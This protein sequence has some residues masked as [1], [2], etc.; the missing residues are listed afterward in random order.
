MA[1]WFPMRPPAYFNCLAMD[2]DGNIMNATEEVRE[3]A[4][5]QAAV[6]SVFANPKR[7]LGFISVGRGFTAPTA[8]SEPDMRGYPHPAPRMIGCCHQCL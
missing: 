1:R 6:C 7:I 8:D 3:L 4:E 2:D 5:C